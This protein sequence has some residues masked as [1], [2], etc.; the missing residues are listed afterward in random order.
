LILYGSCKLYTY[1]I[2]LLLQIVVWKYLTNKKKGSEVLATKQ[3]LLIIVFSQ[4]IPRFGRFFPL[5]SDLKKSAGS[6]AESALAGA[7]YYLLWY[8]LASHVSN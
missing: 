1:Y 6:F 8:L 3:A 2:Y 5:T 4:Y 7:A